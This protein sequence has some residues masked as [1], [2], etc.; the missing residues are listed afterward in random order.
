MGKMKKIEREFL[1]K[2]LAGEEPQMQFNFNQIAEQLTSKKEPARV[3]RKGVESKETTQLIM[4]Y[5]QKGAWK[6]EGGD[7]LK[8]KCQDCNYKQG[9]HWRRQLN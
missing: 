4:N 8:P 6:R 3:G 2:R 9:C 7:L 5:T 1:L